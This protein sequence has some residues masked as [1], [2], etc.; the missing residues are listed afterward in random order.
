MTNW[1]H[2]LTEAREKR[3]I[4]KAALA[5]D[6]KVSGPTVTDWESGAIKNLEATS[7]LKICDVLGIDPWWLVLGKDKGKS[8]ITEGKRPLSNE[9]KKLVLWIER[10]DGLG[11]PAPKIFSHIVSV[12]QIADSLRQAQHT[13]VVRELEEHEQLL[14]PHIEK[15]RAEKHASRKHK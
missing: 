8:G 4:T 1:N 7:L 2:R 6:C 3:G 5:R 14:A 13:D 10:I 11:D 12:L 15:T 9:A